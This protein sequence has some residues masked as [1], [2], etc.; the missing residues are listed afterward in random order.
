MLGYL[1]D[2]A[3]GQ[4]GHDSHDHGVMMSATTE[5]EERGRQAPEQRLPIRSLLALARPEAW[6][7][8]AGTFF[9]FLGG[10]MSL[11]YPQAIRVMI[12]SALSGGIPAID[13]AA[14]F[15]VGIFAVQGAAMATRYLLFTIAGERIVTRLRSALYQHIIAQEIAFFDQRRTGE[16]VS[17]MASDTTVLQNTVTVNLSM[18][19][20]N[21]FR[22]FGGI[23]L[24]ACTSPPLTLAM[25]VIVPPV[26]LGAVLVNRR[27]SKLSRKVQDALA[28]A[29]EVAEETLSGIRT[30]RAFAREQAASASYARAVWEAFALA[31]RRVRVVGIFLG[32]T[33]LASYGAA[34]LVLWYGGRLVAAGSLSVGELTSFILYTLFVAISISALANLWSDFARAS[35]ASA[36][37]FELL[38]REPAIANTGGRQLPQVTGTIELR[39]VDFAYPSRPEAAV[40]KSLSVTIAPGE[41]VALVGPSGAGKST[42]A[43]LVLRLYDPTGGAVLLDGH[44]L[45]ELDPSWLRGRIGVVAQEP[46]L[47][48]TSIADN[49]RYAR[50]DAG[51]A[52]IEAAARNANADTFVEALPERYATQV[53]ERGIQLSGGQKQRVAIARALLKDPRILIFDEAT[54][55]LDA[56]SELLVREALERLMQGRTCIVIAHR[57]STVRDAHRVLVIDEGRIVERGS[58]AELMQ[59]DGLYRRLVEHQL[60]AADRDTQPEAASD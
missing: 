13:R 38:D 1:V 47:F 17:R 20:R 10:G 11:L 50:H 18:V 58:H 36:R 37:V 41:V 52:E 56:E 53:G 40:I 44:D 8:V 32:A 45:R 19:L 54:S 60:I 24:L 48:S 57:L 16:L 5:Q 26:A 29:G 15:M 35:G 31:R 27:I 30:V 39:E 49:I 21:L 55:A 28:R 42:I 12:D 14:I 25:L 4:T 7:L 3:T 9:L 33:S 22:A 51:A 6:Q 46:I 23:A 34:A 59:E 2:L 43:S